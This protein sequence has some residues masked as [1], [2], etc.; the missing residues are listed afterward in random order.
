MR[1]ITPSV[2]KWRCKIQRRSGKSQLTPAWKLQLTGHIQTF[3]RRRVTQLAVH[4][5]LYGL[6]VTDDRSQG[7][8]W[9][10]RTDLKRKSNKKQKEHPQGR[11]QEHKSI[12]NNAPKGLFG[13][14]E[15]NKTVRKSKLHLVWHVFFSPDVTELK[16]CRANCFIYGNEEAAGQVN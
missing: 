5:V 15:G 7:N 4:N 2:C 10:F 9:H 8:I 1:V 11:V 6:R 3:I 12:I 13:P 16:Y 14:R